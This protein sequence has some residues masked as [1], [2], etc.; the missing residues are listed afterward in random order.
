MYY[1][2]TLEEESII[3]FCE[4]TE[5]FDKYDDMIEERT[6]SLEKIK[7]YS[8]SWFSYVNRNMEDTDFQQ[9]F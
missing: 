4:S 7:M 2:N 3:K 1:L 6:G 9:I 5:W 8:T